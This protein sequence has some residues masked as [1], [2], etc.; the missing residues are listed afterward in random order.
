[1]QFCILNLFRKMF[2][3]ARSPDSIGSWVNKQ[4]VL[5]V[6]WITHCNASR[7]EHLIEVRVWFLVIENCSTEIARIIDLNYNNWQKNK[8]RNRTSWSHCRYLELKTV[9]EKRFVFYSFSL[10]IFMILIGNKYKIDWFLLKRLK[11]VCEINSCVI[12][13]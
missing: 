13:D 1:M 12:I 7:G 8:L 5:H 2:L 4:S 9:S 10:F 11:I 3:F 6:H